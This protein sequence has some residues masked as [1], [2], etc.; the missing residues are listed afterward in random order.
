MWATGI[1]MYI[2]LTGKHPFYKEGDSVEEY[3]K[4]ML[5]PQFEFTEGV[6]E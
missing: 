3:S 2:L 1:I 5:N 6:S 4:K